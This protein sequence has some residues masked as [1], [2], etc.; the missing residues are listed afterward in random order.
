M[1]FV[2]FNQKINHTYF[3]DPNLDLFKKIL[4]ILSMI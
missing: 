3:I 4:D 2:N 1:K